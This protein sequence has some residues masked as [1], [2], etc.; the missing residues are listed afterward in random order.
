VGSVEDTYNVTVLSEG[1]GNS[2]MLLRRRRG[3]IAFYRCSKFM[4]NM[5][6]WSGSMQMQIQAT[7]F[8]EILVDFYRT[9]RH[10]KPEDI[11]IVAARISNIKYSSLIHEGEKNT[12]I[13]VCFA[14]SVETRNCFLSAFGLHLS[15]GQLLIFLP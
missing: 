1:L 14:L 15:P 12:S 8:L 6:P 3:T 10:H 11:V 9:T 2:K 7:G 5:P 4:R 13:F